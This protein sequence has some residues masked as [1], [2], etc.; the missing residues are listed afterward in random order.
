MLLSLVITAGAVLGV[1]ESFLP[2]A[3][4]QCHPSVPFGTAAA[5]SPGRNRGLLPVLA[6]SSR[7]GGSGGGVED[8]GRR[9]GE[10]D[11]GG[12]GGDADDELVSSTF[13]IPQAY[14]IT[15]SVVVLRTTSIRAQRFREVEVLFQDRFLPAVH[16][17]PVGTQAVTILRLPHLGSV[18]VP[19][20]AINVE[21]AEACRF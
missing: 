5:A 4:L 2:P 14:A 6:A 1:V 20:R 19:C 21:P 8:Q 10:M 12:G 7:D 18:G 11:R 15:L 17:R 3:A 16:A 13:T 9:W